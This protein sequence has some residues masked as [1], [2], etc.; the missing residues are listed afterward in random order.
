MRT[1]I[2]ALAFVA[3]LFTVPSFAADF[4]RPAPAPIITASPLSGFYIGGN[5]GYGNANRHG[6]F[7]ILEFPA[8]SS[9]S[10][11]RV[12]YVWEEEAYPFN[13]DQKGWLVGGQVGINHILGPQGLFVGAEANAALTGITGV[14]KLGPFS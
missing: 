3:S 1:R 10:N 5:V 9:C 2:V 14:L 8:P 4:I 7:A 6:C 13:Y 11:K 12:E